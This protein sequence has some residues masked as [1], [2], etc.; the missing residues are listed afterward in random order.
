MKYTCDHIKY[1]T[2]GPRVTNLFKRICNKR[3]FCN[4]L[5]EFSI[6]SNESERAKRGKKIY[7]KTRIMKRDGGKR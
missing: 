7:Q 1:N 4:N 3:N 5:V 2:L 6:N